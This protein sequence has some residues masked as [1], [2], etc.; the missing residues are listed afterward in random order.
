MIFGVAACL[1][2]LLITAILPMP[3]HYTAPNF[4]AP[5]DYAAAKALIE[6]KIAQAPLTLSAAGRPR[7]YLHDAPTEHVFVLLHGLTNSPEQFDKL[8]RTLFERGHNVVI[9]RTPGHGNADLMTD[10][11]S[12]FTAKAML[13]Y[14]NLAIMLARPL[15]RHLTV[16]GLSIN[17]AT[18]AWVAQNR[19]DV[20]RAVLLAP[21]F[22][23]R[24]LPQFAIKPLSRLLIRLPNVFLWWDPVHKDQFFADSHAYPRFSTRSIGETMRLG[25]GVFGE[26]E[27]TSPACGAILI[28]TTASDLAASNAVTARLAANWREHRPGSVAAYEFPASENIPHD[29]IDPSQSDQRVDIV[30]PRLIEM[31]ETGKP[32][33]G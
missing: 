20:D 27:T 22:A 32:P 13:D 7:V 24:G 19:V 11:L 15:G 33:G 23:P 31:L 17:G 21:F 26:S 12:V 1:L 6:T 3:F 16:A 25:A 5:G 29:F 28:V 4:P 8:G 10:A 14:A 2:G 30:Y 18:T 9:P